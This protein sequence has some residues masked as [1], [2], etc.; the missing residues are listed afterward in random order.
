MLVYH[1]LNYFILVLDE[2]ISLLNDDL[3]ARRMDK[4][5]YIQAHPEH[6][7]SG[8]LFYNQIKN[9]Y[10]LTPGRHYEMPLLPNKVGHTLLSNYVVVIHKLR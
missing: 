7:K 6:F 2:D 3:T 10:S 5:E 4:W 1:I 8:G 9:K